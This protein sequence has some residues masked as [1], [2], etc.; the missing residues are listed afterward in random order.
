MDREHAYKMNAAPS[1]RKLW[2]LQ[3]IALTNK[4]NVV[5]TRKAPLNPG[6]A[7]SGIANLMAVEHCRK[8]DKYLIAI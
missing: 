6:Y 4:Q 1:S 5:L 7:T 2:R 3:N 8:I